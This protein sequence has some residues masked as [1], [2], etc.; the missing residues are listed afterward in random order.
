MLTIELYTFSL[1]FP[2]YCL[3]GIDELHQ[4][5]PGPDL[6]RPTG[7]S[8]TTIYVIV[9]STDEIERDI[10]EITV[11]KIPENDE[12]K[13]ANSTN[14]PTGTEN[15]AISDRSFFHITIRANEQ[16]SSRTKRY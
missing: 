14:V 1:P 2:F 9:T 8:N 12:S 5:I 11:Y 7:L 3:R 15:F 13:L 4:P 10:Y 6:Q 16:V